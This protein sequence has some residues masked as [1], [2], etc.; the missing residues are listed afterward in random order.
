M[1]GRKSLGLLIN[2]WRC[3]T[4][5]C[6]ALSWTLGN[7]TPAAVMRSQRENPNSSPLENQVLG[8]YFIVLLHS[9]FPSVGVGGEGGGGVGGGGG[10]ERAAT[11]L[12][13]TDTEQDEK[14]KN[15]L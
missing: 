7:P 9:H 14:K 6:F 4:V 8:R 2:I 11:A 10:N 3:R 1:T 12:A 15:P 13:A 5:A